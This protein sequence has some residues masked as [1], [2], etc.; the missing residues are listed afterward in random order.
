MNCNNSTRR[1]SRSKSR[2]KSRS[3]KTRKGTKRRTSSERK[4][5]ESEKHALFLKFHGQFRNIF[6]SHNLDM[7]DKLDE[8][9]E[10]YEKAEQA[11]KRRKL[12][13]KQMDDIDTIRE[14]LGDGRSF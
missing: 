7:R 6:D 12:T 4:A 2:S 13:M 5:R 11:Y 10:L 14:S 1:I 9:N 3:R 8:A